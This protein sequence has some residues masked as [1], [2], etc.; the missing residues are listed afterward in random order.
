MLARV[1]RALRA[2]NGA[3]Q[4]GAESVGVTM[5]QQSVLLALAAYGGDHVPLVDVREE[6]EMDQ[7][8]ASVLLARLVKE[9]L[10]RRDV[11]TDRRA[12]EISLTTKGW[13]TFRRSVDAIRKEMRWAAH[14]G[15]LDALTDELMPYLDYYLGP[16]TT[17]SRARTAR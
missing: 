14:R 13:A 11:S 6:L 8:T 3:I 15:E 1:R 16:R 9:D 4:R 5:Q 10:V 12:A 7:A 17:R 2:V